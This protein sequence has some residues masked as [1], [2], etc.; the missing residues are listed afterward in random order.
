M[1]KTKLEDT[2]MPEKSDNDDLSGSEM[3]ADESSE[4]YSSNEEDI[5][6]GNMAWAK[7]MSNVLNTSSKTENFILSKAK[8]DDDIKRKKTKEI[9]L[10]DSSGKV[11]KEKLTKKLEKS[12][13]EKKMQL[14]ENQRKKAEWE[15]MCRVKPS[16][17]KKER[18]REFVRIATKGVV[19]LFN[20]VQEHQKNIKTKSSVKSEKGN[21]VKGTFMDILKQHAKQDKLSEDS[22]ITKVKQ[23]ETWS[24]L[25]DDFMMGADMKDWDKVSEDET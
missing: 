18:E 17:I 21:S 13:D 10:V 5:G 14:R 8:K 4:N 24:I 15:A 6:S 9:E 12:Y 23:E 1:L 3:D 22:V 16:I 7:A 11:I 25:K 19:H 2:E 20:T